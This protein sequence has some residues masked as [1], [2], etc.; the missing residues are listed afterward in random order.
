MN[1]MAK[2]GINYGPSASLIQGERF[3]RTDF[4]NNP[5]VYAGL[6]KVVESGKKAI[7]T[8]KEMF[9][10]EKIRLDEEQKELDKEQEKKDELSDKANKEWN[11]V[12]GGVLINQ[13]LGTGAKGH[14]SLYKHTEKMVNDNQPRYISGTIDN[15]NNDRI[16]A[17]ASLDG[18]DKLITDFKALRLNYSEMNLGRKVDGS[19]ALALSN[20]YKKSPKGIEMAHDLAQINAQKFVKIDGFGINN[21]VFTIKDSNNENKEITY[22]QYQAMLRPRNY[23]ISAGIETIQANIRKNQNLDPD[24]VRQAISNTLEMSQEDFTSALY[25]DM[26]GKNLIKMLNDKGEALD[27]EII[28]ALNTPA[29]GEGWNIDNDPLTLTPKERDAFIK[30]ATDPD[31]EEGKFWDFE[32]SKK[33]LEDQ[34]YEK[35]ETE[36]KAQVRKGLE[37]TPLTAGQQLTL[38]R[39]NQTDLML[40]EEFESFKADP[41]S[42]I[43]ASLNGRS[44]MLD[45][46]GKFFQTYKNGELQLLR[47]TNNS[48]AKNRVKGFILGGATLK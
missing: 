22:K 30:A 28:S 38:K 42:G 18:Q 9:D 17:L 8:S 44:V 16:Q 25:D 48:T 3:A 13:G 10:K 21:T 46:S 45:K 47:I 40:D 11:A 19:K 4:T 31:Y 15:N 33:I 6:D 43:T 26:S 36:F 14:K 1:N 12:S 39:L 7:A 24:Q 23:S 32:G 5:N 29:K 20:W 27:K 37:G 35:I 34:I 41:K 2:K